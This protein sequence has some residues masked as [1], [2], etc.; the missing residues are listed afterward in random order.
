MPE[1]SA[2]HWVEDRPTGW[3]VLVIDGNT[4]ASVTLAEHLA[5][6]LEAEIEAV[7]TGAE[8]LDLIKRVPFHMVLISMLLPDTDGPE[9]CR[10]MR[11]RE[12]SAPIIVLS[13]G[14]SEAEEILALDAGADDFVTTSGQ[15]PLLLA[16]LRQFERSEDAVF[17]IGQYTFD[18]GHRWLVQ[19][20]TG[21]K[22]ALSAKEA[23]LLKYL[24][25]HRN[26]PVAHRS[27]MRDVWGYSAQAT[28]HTVWTHIYHLRQKIEADPAHPRLLLRVRGGYQLLEPRPQT[29]ASLPASV[30]AELP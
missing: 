28:T 11:E 19:N 23:A 18:C 6:H 3:R 2:L 16:H 5:R 14:G 15:L 30:H 13:T 4:S 12:G 22:T 7:G 9:L 29:N 10:I 27:I 17:S 8:A 24:Y 21:C 20:E 26:R 25:L 1:G